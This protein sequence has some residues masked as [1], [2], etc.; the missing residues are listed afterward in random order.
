M[1]L[2]KGQLGLAEAFAAPLVSD[3]AD[4]LWP[5]VVVDERGTAL[6]LV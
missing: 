6:G 5:T 4:G 2:Y 3:R 1:A